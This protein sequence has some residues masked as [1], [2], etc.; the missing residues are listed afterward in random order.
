MNYLSRRSLGLATLGVGMLLVSSV[1]QAATFRPKAVRVNGT[2]ITPTNS[3][4]V[5]PGDVIQ[6]DWMLSGWGTDIATVQNYQFTVD[7]AAMID[8]EQGDNPTG[9]G[10]IRPLDSDDFYL[11][12]AGAFLDAAPAG[13]GICSSGSSNAGVSCVSSPKDCNVGV[14]HGGTA[15]NRNCSI[16]SDCPGGTCTFGTCIDGVCD[17]G[18]NGGAA[19]AL[20]ENQC[21]GGTCDSRTDYIYAGLSPIAAIDTFIPFP[22]YR[23]GATLITE[24][25]PTD[26]SVCLGG[27]NAGQVCDGDADCAGA[28]CNLDEYYVG[29]AILVVDDL[30]NGV[31]TYSGR[32]IPES[33]VGGSGSGA[34]AFVNFE[35]LTINVDNPAGCPNSGA[36]CLGIGNCQEVS[37]SVCDNQ[38]GVYAGDQTHCADVTYCDCP[39]VVDTYPANCE[40]DARYP[41]GPNDLPSDINAR[42]GMDSVDV[43]M[44]PGTPV[45]VLVPEDFLYRSPQSVFN[46]PVPV[47]VEVLHD[48]TVRVTFD[49]KFPQ[50]RWNC[51]AMPC[52]GILL[53]DWIA[54]WGRLPGD[55]D[56]SGVTSASDIL[57]IIDNLNGVINPP[58]ETYSCDIDVSG[59]CNATDILGVIDLLNGASHFQIYN[60]MA[61]PGDGCP[62]APN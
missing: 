29:S 37:A 25:G 22:N 13:R 42:L 60:N 33:F 55:V 9:C 11:R 28:Q 36:C 34:Q 59:Q 50:L 46:P 19:C 44:A 52:K 30:A 16:P 32:P 10:S 43:T 5:S 40:N 61:Q 26:G 54:C 41:Y 7:N 35:P 20:P 27:A 4:D 47:S 53:T 38:G 12:R 31:F 57:E 51:L 18:A 14:C 56:N 2:A 24:F 8:I 23:Y 49:K 48:T 45:G 15:D 1:A 3:V 17:D 58:L 21:S 62:T 39:T 6:V